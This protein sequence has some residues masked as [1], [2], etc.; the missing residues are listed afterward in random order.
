MEKN[1]KGKK[2]GAEN[3]HLTC[4]ITGFDAFGGDAVNPTAELVAAL[5]DR[6]YYNRNS[7]NKLSKNRLR[8][9]RQLLPT[10]GRSGWN[11]LKQAIDDT[12]A[13]TNGPVVILMNGLAASRDRLSLERFALN[14]RDYGIADNEGALVSDSFVDP[15]EPDLLRTCLPLPPVVKAVNDCG[16][17][18][19]ISNHAG[20]FICNELYFK[21]LTYCRHK[22]RVKAVLFMHVPKLDTFAA[23]CSASSIK[24][25]AR[26]GQA[27]ADNDVK[28]I[29]LLKDAA[30]AVLKAVVSEQ[31]KPVAVT[32]VNFS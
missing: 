31:E 18:C 10:A 22:S 21:A 26:R 3:K 2:K 16:Y 13:Q 1:M 8:L 25:I 7:S 12:M 28:Q 29:R 17:P 9:R 19:V 20:T 23:T 32:A 24:T 4:L 5:P 30:I 27:A 15:A 14:V 6:L 11:T